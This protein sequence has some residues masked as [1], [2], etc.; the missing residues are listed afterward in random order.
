MHIGA[1][2]QEM[3]QLASP[4]LAEEFDTGKIG[5]VVEGKKEIRRVCCS[6]DATPAVVRKAARQKADMLIVHH[7]PIWNPVTRIGGRTADLLRLL[8]GSDMNLYVM[9]TNFDHA[10]GGVNDS[11]C[12]LLSLTDVEPLTL[13]KVGRCT[14]TLPKISKRLGCSLRVWGDLRSVSRLAVVAGSGFDP[15]LMDEAKSLGAEAFL[16]SEMKHAVART[17]PLPCIEAT[18]YALEA[19]AMQDLAAGRGWIYIDDSPALR[20][21]P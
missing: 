4:D 1:F 16:S 3:E 18:H 11:L 6:L 5:L 2:V 20:H 9:H 8:L 7:T 13:G 19:P 15:V 12:R 17:A 21:Y 14:L 10:E